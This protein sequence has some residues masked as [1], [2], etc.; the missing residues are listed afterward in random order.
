MNLILGNYWHGKGHEQ[1]KYN[2]LKKFI[3][4]SGQC[5]N[6]KPW[7]ELLRVTSNIYYDFYNNGGVNVYL[8]RNDFRESLR[9]LNLQQHSFLFREEA[10]E[11]LDFVIPKAWE[12]SQCIESTY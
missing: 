2:E 5:S 11:L 10:D 6:D 8:Y 9:R 7:L 12:E 3:P 1:Q 4:Q